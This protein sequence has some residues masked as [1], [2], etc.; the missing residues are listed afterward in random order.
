MGSG[1]RHPARIEPE[2]V[3]ADHGCCLC[4]TYIL[5]GMSLCSKFRR[6]FSPLVFGWVLVGALLTPALAH[7]DTSSTLTVLGTSDVS[8]SGLVPNLIAPEFENAYP[9]FTFKYVG[10]ATGTAIQNA[11]SGNGGPSALIVHAASLEN[12]FVAG[13]FSYNNQYGNAI[14]RNDF[15]LAG[16]PADPA[17]VS[18]SGNPSHNI[19]QAFANVAAAGVA[20]HATFI[21]RG[22]TNTAPGT[23]VAEH[24][25]WALMGSAGLTPAGVVLCQVSSAD[26]GG[27]TPISSTVQTS[28][29]QPCPDSGTV[30][31]TD[32]PGWYIVNSG[33]NQATNVEAANSCTLGTSG[34]NTCY[35]FT[36]RGTFDYLAS[37]TSTGGPS[38]VPNLTILARDNSASAP[39]G[40][41]QLINYFHVYIINPNVAGETVNLTAAKDFVSFLTSPAFQAQLANYL[42]DTS[43]PGGAPF[44]ADASPIITASGL[45]A[46]D[47]AGKP[48]T[49]TG[50]VSNAEIGYPALSG[51]TVTVDEIEGGIPVPVKAGKT[52]SSGGYSVT[53]TPTSIGVYQVSTGQ[54]SMIENS[55]LSPVY[56]DILSPGAS[57][58]ASMK[59]QSAVTIGSAH[60]SSGEVT[61]AGKV[62][63]AAAD[64]SALVAILARRGGSNASFRE[65]GAISLAAGQSS[66]AVRVALRAGN[67]QIEA[68]YRDPR[69]V[70]PS[71]SAPVSVTVPAGA[72][73]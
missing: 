1:P 38:L 22:G 8:D 55:T 63:P 52:S 66:Y 48:V 28:S 18:S 17:G 71:R 47:P 60:A 26:G 46:V 14:F 10:S 53:F 19:T 15:I 70:L 9:Q 69:Q 3:G 59:V 27:E 68:S 39:G 7:G 16:P 37:G 65:V 42:K 40:A 35:V 29:G 20:H 67:W 56:G 72:R 6:R 62:A 61:V 43:D 33:V 45:P 4:N 54:I 34:A 36:D 41:N 73:P 31:G 50:T 5:S 51:I 32:A 2:Q 49:V 25:I 30:N 64:S 21:S 58:A 13:G 11:E 44:V 24:Q 23:T 57:L 12:Q